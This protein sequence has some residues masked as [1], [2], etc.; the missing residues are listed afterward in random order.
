[1]DVM[2]TWMDAAKK[3]TQAGGRRRRE[4]Y[5]CMIVNG[6][7]ECA[8][9]YRC[10]VVS[11]LSRPSTR[12]PIHATSFADVSIC[13]VFLV[14]GR[15][16]QAVPDR[17]YQIPYPYHNYHTT[18]TEEGA[19]VAFTSTQLTTMD[20]YMDEDAPHSSSSSS[21][22]SACTPANP[23]AIKRR[24]RTTKHELAVLEA[25]YE[26]VGLFSHTWQLSVYSL[27]NFIYTVQSR[28]PSYEARLRACAAIGFEMKAL[29]VWLQNRR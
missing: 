5:Y 13:L 23:Q 27:T 4:E 15:V 7:H 21:S 26:E 8:Y 6:M 14:F 17:E 29:Q 9:A 25:L 11:S 22:S 28:N 12:A 20:G 16:K 10:E 3:Q 2:D 24:R 18:P 19:L 1:M